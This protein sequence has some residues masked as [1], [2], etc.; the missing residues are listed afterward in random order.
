M[1]GTE[2]QDPD[3]FAGRTLQSLTK[4][5]SHHANRMKT[6][7]DAAQRL[8]IHVYIWPGGPAADRLA[9]LKREMA[10]DWEQCTTYANEIK[11]RVSSLME[12]LA[13]N[14]MGLS[15]HEIGM[16]PWAGKQGDGS[17]PKLGN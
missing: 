14:T 4:S 17:P 6:R 8:Q 2:Q 15:R 10:E 3:P 12:Q 16:T 7:A 9:E 11:R 1:S 5:L 13:P